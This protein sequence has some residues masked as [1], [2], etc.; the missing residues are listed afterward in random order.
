MFLELVMS[1][2]GNPWWMAGIAGV[3]GVIL[4]LLTAFG[5]F[6]GTIPWF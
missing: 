5:V 2:L 3:I 6:P 1:I 4:L